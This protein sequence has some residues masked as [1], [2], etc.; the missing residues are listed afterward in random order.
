MI[1]AKKLVYMLLSIILFYS[2]SVFANEVY[3][4]R[5]SGG[6]EKTRIVI[7]LSEQVAFKVYDIP[8]PDRLIIDFDAVDFNLPTQIGTKSYGLIKEFRY[9]N[10]SLEQSRIVFDVTEKIEVV[11]AFIVPKKTTKGA[12]LVVDIIKSRSNDS[13]I[14][15]TKQPP[16]T[17]DDILNPNNQ[18]DNLD[19][20][21]NI[22]S[23]EELLKIVGL[24]ET[25]TADANNNQSSLGQSNIAEPRIEH[26]KPDISTPIKITARVSKPI[27]P[28]ANM[29]QL[30]LAARKNAQAQT[31]VQT[32]G[33][34]TSHRKP[35][36]VIDAGHGGIDGGTVSK[37]GTVEKGIVL[38]VAKKLQKQLNATGKFK[39][40]LTRKG[41]YYIKLRDRVE[42][43]RKV[44]ADLFISLHAD[45][46]AR[47]SSSVRGATVYTLSEKASDKE[48]AAFAR[49]ENRS[50]VLA[51]IQFKNESKIVASILIDLAQRDSKTKSVIFAN[52]AVEQ[53]RGNVRVF[54]KPL[55]FAGFRVLKAP[56]VPSVLV[57]LGYLS[58]VYDEKNLKSGAW[59]DK[60][61]SIL[62][63]SISQ[64]FKNRPLF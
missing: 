37:R 58:N 21:P 1:I 42:I 3:D 25:R 11:A 5:L 43:A 59:Q 9:G 10:F 60:M 2:H 62:Q 48:A 27:K 64:Y 33:A 7:E 56:D 41:D 47:G 8:E 40:Y 51:G 38:S 15:A 26:P 24:A 44:K 34:V 31:D 49:K 16:S 63:R 19:F 4:I 57:E 29:Y 22:P 23:I 61:A 28:P 53:M 14:A 17:I 30:I 32:K 13:V 36:I 52:I 46:V 39:V 54:K 45:S 20:Q 55:K 35:V 6:A 50:D 18:I 12:L